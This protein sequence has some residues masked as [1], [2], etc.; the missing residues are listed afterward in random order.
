MILKVL[1]KDSWPTGHMSSMTISISV[2][3]WIAHTIKTI[4][5]TSTKLIVLNIEATNKKCDV[6]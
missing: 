4:W 6:K 3:G 5:S 1:I 2:K